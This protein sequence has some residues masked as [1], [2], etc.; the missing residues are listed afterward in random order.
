MS[1]KYFNFIT[2]EVEI[3][4]PDLFQPKAFNANETPKYGCVIL[5]KKDSSALNQFREALAAEAKQA[6]IALKSVNTLKTME[7]YKMEVEQRLS[8]QLELGKIDKDTYK[9]KEQKIIDF[10]EKYKDYYITKAK[11]KKKPVLVDRFGKDITDENLQ[12]NGAVA[13]LKLVPAYYEGFGGGITL[14]L[15]GVQII[16]LGTGGSSEEQIKNEF[17]VYKGSIQDGALENATKPV[18]KFDE[19]DNG[20]ELPF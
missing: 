4:F 7:N 2:D 1:K 6:K 18:A 16:K 14:Y 17:G 11:T 19:A 5:I 13:R 12:L 9:E 10:A 20:E 15:E 3:I 8:R